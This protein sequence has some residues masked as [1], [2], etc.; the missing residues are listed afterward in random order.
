MKDSFKLIILSFIFLWIYLFT[1]DKE[2]MIIQN[3]YL[4]AAFILM[5]LEK[6]KK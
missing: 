1:W 3:I 5:Y 4:S 2:L 6:Q